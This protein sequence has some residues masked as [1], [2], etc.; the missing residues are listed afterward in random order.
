MGKTGEGEWEAE[1]PASE[2][3]TYR[4]ERYGNG[5]VTVLYGDRWQTAHTVVYSLCCTPET[6]V[7]PYAN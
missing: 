4:D 3:V 2:W 1:G 5:V 7:S 6:D